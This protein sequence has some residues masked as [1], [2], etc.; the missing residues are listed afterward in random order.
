VLRKLGR[1][2]CNKPKNRSC[3]KRWG[4]G[5]KFFVGNFLCKRG[6]FFENYIFKN[7]RK[8][9]KQNNKKKKEKKQKKKKIKKK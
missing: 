3:C 7:G 6:S 5:G 4:G 9:K 1:N 8:I 2:Y